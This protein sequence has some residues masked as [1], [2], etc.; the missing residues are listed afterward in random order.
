MLSI[1]W[2]KI[3]R[4]QHTNHDTLLSLFDTAGTVEGALRAA[5]FF[6]L[7]IAS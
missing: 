2:S 6:C 1:R 5:S 7:L 4:G 3:M